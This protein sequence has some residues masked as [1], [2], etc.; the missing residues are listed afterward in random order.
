MQSIQSKPEKTERVEDKKEVTDGQMEGR[1]EQ[2]NGKSKNV[3]D[4]NPIVSIL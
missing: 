2:I 1:K 3:M 4:T